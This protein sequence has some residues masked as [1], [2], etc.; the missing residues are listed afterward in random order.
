MLFFC[1]SLYVV[2]NNGIFVCIIICEWMPQWRIAGG[3]IDEMVHSPL[4]DA[5]QFK[6][7]HRTISTRNK[8]DFENNYYYLF[9]Q[10]VF[11][12]KIKSRFSLVLTLAYAQ[13]KQFQITHFSGDLLR[14]S[15]V[16]RIPF[17]NSMTPNDD[18]S[19][20]LLSGS[21]IARGHFKDDADGISMNLW[22]IERGDSKLY[23]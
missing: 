10:R 21:E 23:E 11:G 22:Q 20:L 19:N 14:Y 9:N 16:V 8:Y 1:H 12:G 3:Y 2:H 15:Y 5:M 4:R 13:W 7:V 17:T 6:Y 18:D